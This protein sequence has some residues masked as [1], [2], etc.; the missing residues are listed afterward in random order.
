LSDLPRRLEAPVAVALGYVDAMTIADGHPVEYDWY[1]QYLNCGL[2]LP[3]STGTDW[4]EYD[5]NRVFAQVNGKFSYETWLVGLRA[6]R[7]FI[8]ERPLLELRHR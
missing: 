3:I 6:G 4:W 1:Y 8:S 5:H 2:R 7:T